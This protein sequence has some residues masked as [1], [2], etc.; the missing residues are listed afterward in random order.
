MTAKTTT[1]KE[2]IM[3]LILEAK[4]SRA[5]N[6]ANLLHKSVRG[7]HKSY[8]I[9]GN[10]L[11]KSCIQDL[12]KT[13]N[14]IDDDLPSCPDSE[15]EYLID[16]KVELFKWA[17]NIMQLYTECQAEGLIKYAGEGFTPYSYIS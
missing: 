3:N 5:K 9:G 8:L 17:F 7:S 4:K 15:K 14:E 12:Y 10:I 11:V 16:C 13:I 6:L 1:R 2:D